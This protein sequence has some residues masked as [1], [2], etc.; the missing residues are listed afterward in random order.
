MAARFMWRQNVCI[1]IQFKCLVHLF[2]HDPLSSNNLHFVVMSCNL[3]D[4]PI[5]CKST[6]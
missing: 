5:T 4:R 6:G 2:F 1:Q 3:F